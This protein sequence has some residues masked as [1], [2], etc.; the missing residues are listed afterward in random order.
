MGI[1]RLFKLLKHKGFNYKPLYYDAE[2]EQ[3]EIRK[4]EIEKELG[5]KDIGH[6]VPNI[7]HGSM[8]SHSKRTGKKVERTTNIRLIFIIILLLFLAYM[9]LFR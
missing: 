6:Y 4:R 9:F 2:K 7:T 8:R 3:R 5:I 1:P